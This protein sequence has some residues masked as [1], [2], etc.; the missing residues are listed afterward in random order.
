MQI[1]VCTVEGAALKPFSCAAILD[2]RR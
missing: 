2:Y 1:H